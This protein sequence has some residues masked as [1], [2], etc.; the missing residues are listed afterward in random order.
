MDNASKA[1]I[2]AGGVLIGVLIISI[3]MYLYTL[4]RS[5]YADSMALLGSYQKARF[6][7]E[8]TKYG[9]SD[10][11][12]IPVTGDQVWNI[13]SYVQEA[14]NDDY[15]VAVDIESEGNI[16]VD[17]YRRM[18][19][20]TDTCLRVYNYTYEYGSDGVISRVTINNT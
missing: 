6:N 19:F 20:F 16:T 4:F 12:P 1:L 2:I 8:L 13:L 15:S 14:K 3:G 7:S 10:G 11:T 9:T 17:N 18:L 5:S